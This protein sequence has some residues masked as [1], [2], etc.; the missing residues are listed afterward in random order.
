MQ[1]EID[2]ERIIS[3]GADKNKTENVGNLKFS[4]SLEKYSD[5]EKAEY[6][7]FLNIGDRKVFVA[8]S[9]RTGEDKIILDVFKRLKK[10]VLIIV[11]R[12]LERL[13][14]IENLIKENK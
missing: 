10:Y 12:H 1:S 9:T 3:L 2:K 6:R 11:P 8:G 4:I 14:K 13:S 7:K 5:I